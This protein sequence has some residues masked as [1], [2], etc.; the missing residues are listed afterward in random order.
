M[1]AKSRA[2]ASP[3]ELAA[4]PPM[5]LEPNRKALELAIEWSLEQ[6]LISRKFSVDELFDDTTAM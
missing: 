1:I 2:G 5:G 4:L 3:E 6:R